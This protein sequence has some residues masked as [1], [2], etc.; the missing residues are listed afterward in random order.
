MAVIA[1]AAGCVQQQEIKLV[2]GC[3][4]ATEACSAAC[5][6]NFSSTLDAWR[7]SGDGHPVCICSSYKDAEQYVGG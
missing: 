2:S 4:N 5:M 3:N 1:L 7:C 6:G